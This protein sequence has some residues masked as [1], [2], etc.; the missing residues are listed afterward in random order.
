MCKGFISISKESS[1]GT[2]FAMHGE[3]AFVG[4][5]RMGLCEEQHI[6][7]DSILS[8]PSLL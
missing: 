1:F 7:F 8:D 5:Q 3:G 4:V 6:G 2:I